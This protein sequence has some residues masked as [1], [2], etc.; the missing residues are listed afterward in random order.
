[1]MSLSLIIDFNILW[2]E[3]KITDIKQFP[4]LLN[5]NYNGCIDSLFY[6]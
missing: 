5:M 1:M 2:Y 6:L 3:D 4:D